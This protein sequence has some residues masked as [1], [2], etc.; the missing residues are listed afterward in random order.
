MSTDEV[1]QFVELI[2]EETGRNAKEELL[3]EFLDDEVFR[4]VVELAYNPLI[5]FGVLNVSARDV[6]YRGEGQFS[7]ATWTLL[8]D[9]SNREATGGLA[10]ELVKLELMSL[11]E[12]SG[13]LLLRILAKDLR[14][15]ITVKLINEARPG[16]L[17]SF[18]YMRCSLP[19]DVDLGSFPWEIGVY[20]QEKADGMFVNINL[21]GTDDASMYTRVGQPLD[22]SK[23]RRP[24]EDMLEKLPHG[25]QYHGEVVVFRG[26]GPMHRK[27]SNGVMNR[28]LKGGSF[29]SGTYPVVFLWD[30]IP[31]DCVKDKGSCLVPYG[32][33][34]KTLI[35]RI[36]G[37]RR[38]TAVRLISTR[39]VNSYEEAKKHFEE[40]V[41]SGKEGTIFKSPDAI[42]RDG[43]SRQQVKMKLEKEADLRVVGISAGTG[44]NQETFGSLIC[45]TEDGLLVVGVSGFT[46]E[47]RREIFGKYDT[48]WKDAIVAVKYNS[49]ISSGDEYSLYLP[50]FVEKRSDKQ[51]A[52]SLADLI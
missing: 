7:E 5:T 30:A 47:E 44:K 43:T 19:K 27:E 14:A 31:L 13:D 48:E 42:W 33:R 23:M 3:R 39:V 16:T 34:F 10:R 21:V 36:G 46:D 51:T 24:L 35:D 50:R 15:G 45:Q 2:A 9:L 22:F 26:G 40:M 38:T 20:S 11:T 6:P 49:V 18:P 28:I 1:F 32:L 29:E 37:D 8:R 12:E 4:K 41:E 17:P 25:M 52:D